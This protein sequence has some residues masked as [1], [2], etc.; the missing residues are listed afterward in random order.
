MELFFNECSLHGQFLDIQN[1]ESSLDTLMEI[2]R[3]AKKYDRELYCHRE[4]IQ[5]MVTHQLNLPQIIGSINKSKANA[6][7]GWLGRSGPFWEDARRHP[8]DEYLECQGH[9]VTDTAIGECAYL[10]FS[11]KEAQMASIFP[12]NWNNTPL[13]VTWHRNTQPLQSENL[14]NHFTADTL[15]AELQKA[16]PPITVMGPTCTLMPTTIGRPALLRR[17]ILTAERKSF[18]ISC[19]QKHLRPAKH[20]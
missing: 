4:T 3:V 10:R 12:S 20:A 5:A 14:I 13:E 15:E 9:I 8:A 11:S 17:R 1:F 2:R 19:S 18:C 16:A 7:M 6:L